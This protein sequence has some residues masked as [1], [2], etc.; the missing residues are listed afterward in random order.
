MPNPLQQGLKQ[1]YLLT[2]QT[3]EIVLMPNPLQQGLKP[4]QFGS[5]KL[6]PRVLMP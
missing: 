5:G 2:Q 4:C 3:Y 6:K 1:S